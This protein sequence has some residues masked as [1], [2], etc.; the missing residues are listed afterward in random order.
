MIKVEA[1]IRPE[2]VNVVTNALLEVGCGGF[3]YQNVTGQGRQGGTEVFT[4]RGG[5]MAKAAVSKTLITT[6]V[7]DEMK[8]A[9]IDA[10]VASAKGSDNGKIGDGKIIITQVSDVV[11]VRTGDRGESAI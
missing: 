7:S 5:A 4:G 1:I 10:I 3:N 8:E 2:R 11:R 6:V 9:V